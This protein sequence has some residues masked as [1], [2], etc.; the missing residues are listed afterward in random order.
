MVIHREDVHLDGIVYE[1]TGRDEVTGYF[2]AWFCK[3][4]W[5]GGVKYQ[6]FPV[7]TQAVE[8][9]KDRAKAHHSQMHNATCSSA[10]SGGAI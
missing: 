4:C 7:I 10:S 5:Q 3:S 2:G 6:L 9:A 1:L 8:D